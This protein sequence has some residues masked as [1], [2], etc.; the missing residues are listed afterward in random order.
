MIRQTI[1]QWYNIFSSIHNLNLPVP[2]AY[3]EVIF[4]VIITFFNIDII[5]IILFNIVIVTHFNIARILWSM[6]LI[7]IIVCISEL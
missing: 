3:E 7:F 1:K 6:I 2:P 5:I 4:I